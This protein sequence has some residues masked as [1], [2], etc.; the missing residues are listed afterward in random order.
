MPAQP[1]SSYPK[2]S[3]NY[4]FG[5]DVLVNMPDHGALVAAVIAGW[6]TTETH[7]G[8]MLAALIG[9]KQP[10]AL[11]MYSAARSFDVQR[12]LLKA[13]VEETMAKRYSTLLNATLP[14]LNR[15]AK[16]RHKFGHWI[17]GA[18][19]DPKLTALLLVEPK[20]FWNLTAAQTRYWKRGAKA[21]PISVWL[22]IPKLDHRH[23]FVYKLRDLQETREEIER[24]FSLADA[25]RQ[26]VDAKGSRRRE[27]WNWIRTQDQIRSESEGSKKDCLRSIA[28]PPR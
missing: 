4:V 8:R 13:A 28:S 14:V 27:I 6:S 7:L 3:G 17:W 21:D 2:W 26:L 25:F 19:A 5:N 20:H 24:A 9:A 12:D 18:S 22:N 1:A 11:S 15:A 23:I 16:Q 10:V